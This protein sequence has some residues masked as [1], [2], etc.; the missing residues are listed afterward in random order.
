MGLKAVLRRLGMAKAAAE[1]SVSG[2]DALLEAVA[3]KSPPVFVLFC[4]SKDATGQ[5]WCP[6]C[7]AAEPVVA[8]AAKALPA[9]ATL[10]HCDVGDRD[11]SLPFPSP[12]SLLLSWPALVAA[13]RTPPIPSAQT[14]NSSSPESQLSSS[15]TP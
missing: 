1:L 7:V 5:S 8:A 11:L 10:V 2:Y 15:G 3:G 9:T 14:P 12:S 13:G 6:D 4:G